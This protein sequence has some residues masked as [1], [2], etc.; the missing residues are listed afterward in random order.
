MFEIDCAHNSR[1]LITMLKVSAFDVKALRALAHGLESDPVRAAGRNVLRRFTDPN[2]A[3][4]R[5]WARA[6][7]GDSQLYNIDHVLKHSPKDVGS[8]NAALSA[9]GE[10]SARREGRAKTVGKLGLL[11]AGGYGGA[12]LLGEP[13]GRLNERRDIG[14]A[15]ESG[16]PSMPLSHRLGIALKSVFSPSSLGADVNSA[17]NQ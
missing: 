1:Y 5:L 6:I 17:L 14:Q 3:A 9:L 15:A 2:S 10:T 12:K 11:G 7:S 4:T 13:A 16:L 8:L